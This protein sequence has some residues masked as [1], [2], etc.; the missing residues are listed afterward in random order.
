MVW[1]GQGLS[2]GSVDFGQGTGLREN[3]RVDFRELLGGSPRATERM[4]GVK[5]VACPC[6]GSLGVI[7]KVAFLGWPSLMYIPG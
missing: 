7:L 6:G 2:S 3:Q 1:M 4:D 5:V